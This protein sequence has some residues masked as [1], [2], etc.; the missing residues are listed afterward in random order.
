MGVGGARAELRGSKFLLGFAVSEPRVCPPCVSHESRV[1]TFDNIGKGEREDPGA[2]SPAPLVAA[3]LPLAS[4]GGRMRTSE[5]DL[6]LQ[7]SEREGGFGGREE[8]G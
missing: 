2:P 5:N 7:L 6:I 3:A 4:G 8:A 1:V